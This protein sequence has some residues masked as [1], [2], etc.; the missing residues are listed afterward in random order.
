MDV[1]SFTRSATNFKYIELFCFKL[2]MFFRFSNPYSFFVTFSARV[3][4]RDLSLERQ[5]GLKEA[6]LFSL[7]L[8]TSV[9]KI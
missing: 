5:E 4:S 3:Q 1:N 7:L 9:L 2:F 8:E 6:A